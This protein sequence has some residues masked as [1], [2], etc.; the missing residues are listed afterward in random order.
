M[1]VSSPFVRLVALPAVPYALGMNKPTTEQLMKDLITIH[2]E[3]QRHVQDKRHRVTP[4]QIQVMT[5][6]VTSLNRFLIA[7]QAEAA[8]AGKVKKR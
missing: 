6:S 3:V 4:L 7:W 8:K 5:E 2:F 1:C